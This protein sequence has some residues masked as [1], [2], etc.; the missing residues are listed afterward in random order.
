M[1]TDT[2]I[3]LP[4]H[5]H[6]KDAVIHIAVL[7]QQI[8]PH[9]DFLQDN[10]HFFYLTLESLSFAVLE[11][12]ISIDAVFIGPDSNAGQMQKLSE[13]LKAHN[14]PF[15]LYSSKYD[16]NA[17][18]KALELQVDDYLLGAFTDAMIKRIEFIKKTKSRANSFVVE[19]TRS[20]E[21][22]QSVK[23]W[24][25]KRVSDIILSSVAIILLSPLLLVIALLIKLESRGPIFYV[26]KRA[27]SGYKIFDFYKFRSM[28]V[29]ADQELRSLSH[30]NQ[31]TNNPEDGVFFKIKDDPRVTRFGAFLRNSS[32]DELPQLLNV[33]KGDMS[34]VGNRPLP[35]YEAERL[36]KDQIAWRFLA[37]AGITGL[38]QVTKRGNKQMSLDERIHLDIEYAM[39]NS[40]LLDMKIILATFPALIQKEKV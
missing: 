30:L 37:P 15:I 18:R 13:L 28:R 34:L 31:Y 1:K 17:K 35:L 24:K 7:Q 12:S 14:I 29:G 2:D 38:W 5:K 20:I 25:L 16:E 8:Q 22:M 23:I 36:T 26:S 27:G 6:S 32:L 40:F 11:N 19:P 3:A 39:K 10:W 4:N 21:P 33:L 9:S